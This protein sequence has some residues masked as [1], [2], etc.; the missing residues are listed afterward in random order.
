[1]YKINLKQLNMQQP[2]GQQDLDEEKLIRMAQTDPQHFNGIYESYFDKIFIFIHRRTDDEALAADLTSQ[3]FLK[4]LQNIKKFE[5]RG[6]SISAW[7]Y[8]IASNEINRHFRTKKK[9]MIFSLE[10]SVINK[11]LQENEE[12]KPDDKVP[13]LIEHLQ[14]LSTAEISILELR[15]FEDKNFKEIAYIL[16]LSESGAKMR[17]YRALD[18]L[19]QY[20]HL[21]IKR[22]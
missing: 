4:A 15:F 21:K 11:L 13:I 12:E 20:F 8:K 17:T 6:I 10:E 22:L 14:K 1:M 16:D 2:T 19:K 7:L 3:T 5:I 9:K 18:K